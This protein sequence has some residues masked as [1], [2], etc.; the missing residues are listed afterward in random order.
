[1][2]RTTKLLIATAFGLALSLN[3]N[4]QFFMMGGN[5]A[6]RDSLRRIAEADYSNMLEQLGIEA[7]REGRQPNSKDESKHPNY[8]ELTANPYPFY[9]DALTTLDG[10]K[11]KNVKMWNK[12]RRPELVRLFEDNVYGRI[13]DNVP[14]VTWTVTKED[15]GL[16][17]GCILCGFQLGSYAEKC[18]GKRND[19]YR[20]SKIP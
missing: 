4:A 7:P 9:P 17:T 11:V 13:P 6:S 1:M 3:S 14:G 18:P 20:D 19:L 10:K 15:D 5:S 12:V 16:Q 8:N 2:N